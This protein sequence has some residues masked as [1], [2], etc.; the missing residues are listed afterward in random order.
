MTG[1]QGAER[2]KP[3]Q[4]RECFDLKP[5][6]RQDQGNNDGGDQHVEERP[7][8]SLAHPLELHTLLA[9]LITGDGVA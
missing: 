5:A 7:G 8:I 2:H 4:D 9:M 6:N 3:D 1:I